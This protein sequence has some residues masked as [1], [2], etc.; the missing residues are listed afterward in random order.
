MDL[1][2]DSID[3]I[4]ETPYKV[5]IWYEDR[6]G[7][8]TK[9][10]ISPIKTLEYAGNYYLEA[11]CH[12]KED[13]RK[14]ILTSISTFEILDEPKN[15]GIQKN[16]GFVFLNSNTKVHLEPPK[17]YAPG[18]HDIEEFVF[19]CAKGLLF[20][21]FLPIVALLSGGSRRGS[22]GSGISSSFS[23]RR[24]RDYYHRTKSVSSC[25]KSEW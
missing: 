2:I 10:I 12:T 7:N 18:S 14:F 3:K 11:Y 19:A 1:P 15:V 25:Y 17:K 5:K 4:I 21:M 13:N 24:A 23:R 9:R 16:P 20:L 22:R 6:A 8:K